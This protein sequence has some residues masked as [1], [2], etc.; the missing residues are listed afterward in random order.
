MHD[1]TFLHGRYMPAIT[2]TVDKAFDYHT[3]QFMTSGGVELFYDS[4]RYEMRGCWAWS[5]FPGPHVRFN[6]WPRGRPWWHRYIAFKGLR[7]AEWRAN[8]LMLESPQ[9]VRTRDRRQ[10]AALMDDMI[11]HAMQPRRISQLRAINLLEQMLIHL[12]GWRSEEAQAGPQ[13][14]EWYDAVIREL[15]RDDVEPDYDAIAANHY[16]SLSTLRRRFR[17]VAGQSPHRYRLAHRA[18]RAKQLLGE[19]DV[20]IK[21]IADRLR[22]S[23]V[24]HFSKQFKQQVGVTPAAFRRSRQ[25]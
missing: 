12:A 20:P 7:I 19:T 13:A 10:F 9:P 16:M 3:L 21:Q 5:A 14:P 23:D 2:A 11:G 22:F 18:A 25:G 8:G 1:V 6:E 15:Q 4:E 24:F 17:L